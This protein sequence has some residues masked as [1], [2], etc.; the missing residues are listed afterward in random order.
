MDIHSVLAQLEADKQSESVTAKLYRY[1]GL[2]QTIG[3]FSQRLTH[4]Q[5]LDIAFDSVNELVTI[6]HALLYEVAGEP[7]VLRLRK[8]KGIQ[9]APETLP[10]TE[11]MKSLPLVGTG[12]LIRQK[13]IRAV[14]GDDLCDQLQI[15]ALVPFVDDDTLKGVIL[16][17]DKAS[18]A[19]ESDDAI[20]LEALMRLADGSMENNRRY[21]EL[22]R[23]NRE[24][25]T[26]VFDLFAINQ[27]TRLLLGETSLDS[28]AHLSVDVF[29]E[30]TRSGR[31]SFFLFREQTGRQEML[32]YLNTLDTADLPVCSLV[33][34][35]A[36]LPDPCSHVLDLRSEDGQALFARLFP[37]EA[38][39][40]TT[41]G[42]CYLVLLERHGRV[43][44][45]V[46]LGERI[47]GEPYTADQFEVIESL[48]AAILIAV[49]NARLIEALGSQKRALRDRLERLLSLSTLI[50]N[51]NSSGN[52]ETLLELT[53]RTLETSFEVRKGMILLFDEETTTLHV[54][55][56]IGFDGSG[57]LKVAG[58]WE[59]VLSGTV[60]CEAGT[61]RL[62][63]FFPESLLPTEDGV[64]GILIE[65]IYH[66][67]IRKLLLGVIVVLKFSETSV[68]E[69]EN[70]L[71]MEAISNHLSLMIIALTSLNR[72]RRFRMP[73]HV[74]EF[75]REL[76]RR[77]DE[78]KERGDS[79]DLLQVSDERGYI[80]RE[81]N[82]ARKL[83][84]HYEHVYP[85]AHN[86]V[87][88]LP[89][90]DGDT[91]SESMSRLFGD[92]EINIRVLRFGRDFSTFKEFFD[93]Q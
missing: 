70:L 73:L 37:G 9:D 20:I 6:A 46:T 40:A 66:T 18:G 91:A 11:S 15:R 10:M 51:I 61:K 68:R 16:L 26:K 2:I 24:M 90:E 28:L 3:L 79:F 69:P 54:S 22:A 65:P 47:G 12:I 33:Y 80:F 38:P 83:E 60:I 81:N 34:E 4:E 8:V 29:A 88:V 57:I 59:P 72:Q 44:G 74:E 30:I 21:G 86:H 39:P 75:K 35:G 84:E 43:V 52:M 53:G 23:I 17:G 48:A 55:R 58:A 56:T 78:A 85:V 89:D 7:T 27:A 42:A 92:D 63:D 36:I 19:F 77:V 82:L 13:A 14:L 67:D 93:L 50:K 76:R 49:D 71:T 41:L 25:D 87:F 64:E 32:A 31:T 5:C 45:F 1:M 62:R